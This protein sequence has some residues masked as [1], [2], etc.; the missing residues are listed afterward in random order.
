[1]AL[2][3]RDQDRLKSAVIER[4]ADLAAEKHLGLAMILAGFD[5]LNGATSRLAGRSSGARLDPGELPRRDAGA[6]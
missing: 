3:M 6:C 2:D 4:V 5:I 1:M